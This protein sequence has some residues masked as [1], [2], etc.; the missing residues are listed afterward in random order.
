MSGGIKVGPLRI[1]GGLSLVLLLSACGSARDGTTTGSIDD[2]RERHPIVVTEAEHSMDVPI[3]AGDHGLNMASREVIRGFARSRVE[4][5]QGTVQ[6]LYP[7]G[8]PNSAAAQAARSQIVAELK[9]GGVD[10]RYIVEGS[11][12]V[13]GGESAPIRLSYVATTAMVASTCGEWPKNIAPDMANRQYHNFG[14]AYQNNLA[15]Q[16]ANPSD[17]IGPRAM[18]PADAESRANALE[19]YRTTYTELKDMSN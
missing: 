15:A 3:A 19:R 14:C 8:A 13:P 1:L 17:L 16:I 6:V 4:R 9:R 12:A 5:S 7:Q 2:Y 18:T 10:S 11:Y